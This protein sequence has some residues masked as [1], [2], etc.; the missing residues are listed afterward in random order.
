ML[1]K[2]NIANCIYILAYVIANAILS[3]AQF[4]ANETDQS[5][6]V[7]TEKIIKIYDVSQTPTTTQTSTPSTLDFM[8]EHPN[9][10]RNNNDYM[11]ESTVMPSKPNDNQTAF[12]V[13]KINEEIA[14]RN[15][16]S[17]TTMDTIKSFPDFDFN[18][19]DLE[20][21]NYHK[22]ETVESDDAE[23][24]VTDDV[25]SSTP[26]LED[27]TLPAELPNDVKIPDVNNQ[28]NVYR[29]PKTKS[30]ATVNVFVP[31]NSTPM[32]QPWTDGSV[33]SFQMFTEIYD[34]YRWNI[35]VIMNNV[36]NKCGLDMR[37]YLNALNNEVEWALKGKLLTLDYFNFNYCGLQKQDDLHLLMLLYYIYRIVKSYKKQQELIL[38]LAIRT[39][40]FRTKL[41]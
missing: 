31:N 10:N 9:K 18:L 30:K 16:G 22:K 29:V 26:T 17:N 24:I 6:A 28:R 20:D 7:Q 25:L 35:N 3:N 19:D 12:I 21:L 13:E 39:T 8:N 4:T 5:I 11:Y 36:S 32:A 2:T 37:V 38:L 41:L 34:Q 40:T 33:K 15:N 14:E 1:R 23:D 27:L